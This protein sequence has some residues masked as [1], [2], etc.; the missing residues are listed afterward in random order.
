MINKFDE[1]K[2]IKLVIEEVKNI[3]KENLKVK[4]NTAIKK[5]FCFSIEVSD[6]EAIRFIEAVR[7]IYIIY[8]DIAREEIVLKEIQDIKF[9]RYLDNKTFFKILKILIDSGMNIQDHYLFFTELYREKIE[10]MKRVVP[11][12]SIPNGMPKVG[13]T[14]LSGTNMSEKIAEA[15]NKNNPLLSKYY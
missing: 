12:I 2:A 4:H 1:E 9:Y 5:P 8:R 14:A 13:I 10:E 6:K 7:D 3:I 15:V 11:T